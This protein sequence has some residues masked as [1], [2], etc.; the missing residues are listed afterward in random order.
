MDAIVSKNLEYSICIY[1]LSVIFLYQRGPAS[2]KTW[3]DGAYHRGCCSCIWSGGIAIYRTLLGCTMRWSSATAAKICDCLWR[4]VQTGWLTVKFPAFCMIARPQAYPA[5][6]LPA[7]PSV[8]LFFIR[9]S[10]HEVESVWPAAKVKTNRFSDRVAIIEN[11][12]WRVCFSF[13]LTSFRLPTVRFTGENRP[14]QHKYPSCNQS[15]Y[16]RIATRRCY[17]QSD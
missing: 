11:K 13:R 8:G 1:V 10:E 6:Y 14:L 4:F 12:R 3:R 9:V 17:K 5:M 2:G 16:F 15:W 7:L